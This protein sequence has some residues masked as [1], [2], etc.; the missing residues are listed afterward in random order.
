[1]CLKAFFTRPS[2]GRR[3]CRTAT[4]KVATAEGVESMVFELVADIYTCGFH[5]H[6]RNEL[7]RRR[8]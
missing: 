8:F 6:T 4:L 1:M 3:L 5:R 7:F 2:W